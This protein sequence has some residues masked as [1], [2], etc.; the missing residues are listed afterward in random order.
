MKMKRILSIISL[1]AAVM[2]LAQIT[3]PAQEPLGHTCSDC[4]YYKGEFSISNN[5]GVAINYSVRWGNQSQWKKMRLESGRRMTHR[6]PLGYNRNASAP[7]PYVRFDRVGGD[8]ANFTSQ[9]YRMEFYAVRYGGYGPP[10]QNTTEP[11]RYVF[12]FAANG[13]DLDIKAMQ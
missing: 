10:T 13:R 5:T 1:A 11:K 6:Y 2:L 7:T 8:G 12:R 4:P 9:E 3:A